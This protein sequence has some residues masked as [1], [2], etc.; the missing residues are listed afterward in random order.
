MFL[1]PFYLYIVHSVFII[2]FFLR[3]TLV[4][5]KDLLRVFIVRV[6]CQRPECADVLL[7]PLIS[8]IDQTINEATLS[9]ADIF[10]V[11]SFQVVSFHQIE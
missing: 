1:V 10:K 4:V 7:R 3:Q 8:W 11:I 9:D 2:I 5:I 6:A